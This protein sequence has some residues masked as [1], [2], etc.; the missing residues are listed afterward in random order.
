[1][2]FVWLWMNFWD[3]YINQLWQMTAHSNRLDEPIWRK[4]SRSLKN[5]MSD[6]IA[7]IN[8]K[9][10]VFLN[11]H[12]FRSD[13]EVSMGVIKP[14]EFNCVIRLCDQK[15]PLYLIARVRT[16]VKT[17]KNGFFLREPICLK[18]SGSVQYLNRFKKI[19]SVSRY[20]LQIT[21]KYRFCG[22]RLFHWI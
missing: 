3:F 14:A 1:M 8:R 11:C 21:L 15:I 9:L 6:N 7:A 10:S 18:F 16:V 19:S 5:W 20:F 17:G 12:V 2:F 22:I 4:Q 13:F